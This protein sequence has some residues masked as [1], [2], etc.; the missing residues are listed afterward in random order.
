MRAWMSRCASLLAG[1]PRENVV[2]DLA[3]PFQLQEMTCMPRSRPCATTGRAGARRR[4]PAPPEC[5]RRRLRAGAGWAAAPAGGWLP[6]R[7]R[8]ARRHRMSPRWGPG[9]P[10]AHRAV[11]VRPGAARRRRRP[12]GHARRVSSRRQRQPAASSPRPGATPASCPP[13]PATGLPA[14]TP[15]SLRSPFPEAHRLL[16]LATTPM[17]RAARAVGY[18]WSR[19]RH[20][21]QVRARWHHYQ[22]QLKAARV[23]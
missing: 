7:Q 2:V 20:R 8:S 12:P 19:W 9:H 11:H 21:Q 16:C 4:G 6:A 14:I 23:T 18:A 1:D 15:A 10:G 17:S 22:T 13:V 3:G 5:S